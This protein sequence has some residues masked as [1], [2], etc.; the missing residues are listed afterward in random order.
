M[1]QTVPPIITAQRTLR[2]PRLRRSPVPIWTND[3]KTTKNENAQNTGPGPQWW[4]VARE[5]LRAPQVYSSRPARH[6]ASHAAMIGTQRP[7]PWMSF[8]V[9][10]TRNVRPVE[11]VIS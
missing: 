8:A 7:Y 1:P 11:L 5:P 6:M 9:S 4:T 2:I 3:S 10:P